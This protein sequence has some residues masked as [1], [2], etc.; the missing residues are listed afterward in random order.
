MNARTAQL[1]RWIK[2]LQ[3]QHADP[4]KPPSP[5]VLELS[6]L[7]HWL[8]GKDSQIKNKGY[9]I[10]MER[11]MR[12]YAEGTPFLLVTPCRDG[13]TFVNHYM[14]LDKVLTE[15]PKIQHQMRLRG[16][17]VGRTVR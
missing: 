5:E 7:L 4:T 12:A 10:G 6:E 8:H 14:D 2:K 13:V 17:K 3:E 1:A 9:F 15:I 11:L 16:H